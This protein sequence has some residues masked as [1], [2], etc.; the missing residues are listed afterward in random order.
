MTADQIEIMHAIL[1]HIKSRRRAL[2]VQAELFSLIEG[3][4]F[5]K[6]V[7]YLTDKGLLKVENT[8]DTYY[9]PGDKA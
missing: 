6:A 2:T 7:K 9:S 4:N 1:T 8:P 5:D 3:D